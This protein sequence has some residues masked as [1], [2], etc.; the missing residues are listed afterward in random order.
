[1]N[2]ELWNHE[3]LTGTYEIS[4][5]IDGISCVNTNNGKFSKDGKELYNIPDFEGSIAEIFCGTWENTM[6]KVRSSTKIIPVLPDEI[7]IIE[8][9]IDERLFISVEKDPTKELILSIFN[10]IRE[11]G[12][13]GLILKNISTNI[14][15]KVKDTVTYDVKITG[16]YEGK[17]GWCVGKLG[18]FITPMGNV[19]GGFTKE[20]R[21][22]FFN[23]TTLIGKTV[24]VAC[25]ELTPKGKFRHSRFIRF[26]E[27]K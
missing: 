3:D 18:G 23:D 13:E 19:G 4:I 14:R 22:E 2:F 9:S 20:Q 5:K 24:E 16:L 11:K 27:D 21:V 8:P 1:M 17:T 7:Y 25:M 15:Y 10:S 12:F 6:S 26:R